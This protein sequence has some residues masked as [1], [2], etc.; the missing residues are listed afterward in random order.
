MQARDMQIGAK[1]SLEAEIEKLQETV[2]HSEVQRLTRKY[3]LCS[4]IDQLQMVIEPSYKAAR[5]ELDAPDMLRHILAQ[6]RAIRDEDVTST[7]NG[8]E[9]C[10]SQ[11]STSNNLDGRSD[12]NGGDSDGTP[13]TDGV[14]NTSIAVKTYNYNTL[15]AGSRK[16]VFAPLTSFS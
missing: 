6:M 10:T 15:P 14:I 3:K 11:A 1:E 9:A 2:H 16:F 5:H 13:R 7:Q 8:G 12:P 4:I